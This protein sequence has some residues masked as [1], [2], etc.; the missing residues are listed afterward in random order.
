[1]LPDRLHL[2][3]WAATG[4]AMT[5][6]SA[7]CASPHPES[8]AAWH[9]LESAGL[10]APGERLSRI[11]GEYRFTEGPAAMADGSILFTDQPSNRIHRW[12]EAKGVSVFLEPASR[13]NG[14]YPLPGGGVAACAEE[15]RALIE[16][17]PDGSTRVIADGFEGIAFNSPNDVW[18]HPKGDFFVTDPVYPRPWD[19]GRK[20]LQPV[21]GVYRVE[22]DGSV[23]CVI[24]DLAQPNGIVGSSDGRLLF[25]SDIASRKVWRYALG[26]GA[27]PSE[28]TVLCEIASDGMTLDERGNLYLT[29]NDGVTIV[30]PSGEVLGT[31][32]VPE[33]WTANVT[34]GGK[35][36]RTLFITASKHA[37]TLKMPVRGD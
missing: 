21:H 4:L 25:V 23:S 31:I 30:A 5:L 3:F 19:P 26:S 24:G 16:I 10:V 29:N 33:P 28:G 34:F 15:P 35:D 17:G 27:L 22:P 37:Y 9:R 36:H 2:G 7:A 1:M 8:E 6:A 14:L 12:D 32:P 13:S 20:P 18:R 11:E